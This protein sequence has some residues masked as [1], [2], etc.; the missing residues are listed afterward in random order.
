[1][2]ARPDPPS[3]GHDT[4]PGIPPGVLVLHSIYPGG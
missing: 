2:T 1:M 3:A 4:G